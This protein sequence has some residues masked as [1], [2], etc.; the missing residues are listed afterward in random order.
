MHR[1]QLAALGAALLL[2]PVAM[3]GAEG[4]TTRG[5]VTESVHGVD[6]ADP[7]R[8]LEDRRSPRT[9]AWIAEQD[10]DARAVLAALPGRADIARRLDRPLE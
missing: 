8:W 4:P 2:G 1:R 6:V 5:T 7:H 10:A 3:A 9:R